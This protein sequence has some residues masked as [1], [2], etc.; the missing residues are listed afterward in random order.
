MYNSSHLVL[1]KQS[2]SLLHGKGRAVLT[3]VNANANRTT[4]PALRGIP[5]TGAVHNYKAGIDCGA[6]AIT[7]SSADVTGN[8]VGDWRA[9]IWL[10][11][12]EFRQI[13]TEKNDIKTHN[14]RA[15]GLTEVR[16]LTEKARKRRRS[17]PP[18]LV[19]HG[20]LSHSTSS[21]LSPVSLPQVV[22]LT[23]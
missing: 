5:Q 17:L 2:V 22:N 7:Q 20:L 4:G 11:R 6:S 19:A 14:V 21:T 15:S 16:R 13:N 9:C 18:P 8:L 23:K 12:G 1:T 10:V 3:S